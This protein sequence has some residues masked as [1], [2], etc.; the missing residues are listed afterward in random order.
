[1]GEKNTRRYKEQE[2]EYFPSSSDTFLTT[3]VSDNWNTSLLHTCLHPQLSRAIRW[4]C[5]KQSSA[6]F[7]CCH[8]STYAAALQRMSRSQ[9][10]LQRSGPSHNRR[11]LWMVP[12]RKACDSMADCANN[13]LS[14][15]LPLLLGL[16]S[17]SIVRSMAS[18][19]HASAS[20]GGGE[21]RLRPKSRI[22][23]DVCEYHDSRMR[24]RLSISPFFQGCCLVQNSSCDPGT[25]ADTNR[26]LIHQDIAQIKVTM[27]H[28]SHVN[29]CQ[30]LHK[31]SKGP[32]MKTPMT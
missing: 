23:A 2:E 7:T 32:L 22:Q 31:G 27:Q 21:M 9:M 1:L 11:E 6:H 20:V 12:A 24:H 28:T 29:R 17:V 10:H 8:M 3:C 15:H 26:L 5:E 13:C 25:A 18:S 16:S 14:K 30:S 4:L 19:L